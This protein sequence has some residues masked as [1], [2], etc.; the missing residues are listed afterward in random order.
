MVTFRKIAFHPVYRMFSLSVIAILVLSHPGY[1]SGTLVA[2]NILI[3]S[4]KKH[5]LKKSAFLCISF[6]E[7]NS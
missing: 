4:L 5:P 6:R 2:D 7:T 1:K 3:L